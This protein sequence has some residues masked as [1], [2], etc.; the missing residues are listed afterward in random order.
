MFGPAPGAL[1]QIPTNVAYVSNQKGG[2]TVIDLSSF[3]PVK[4]LPVG[5]EGP[6]GIAITPDGKYLVT[7][8]QRTTDVSIIDTS[9]GRIVRRI[10]IGKNPEFLRLSR[11]GKTAF[12]TYEPSAEGRPPAAG[13]KENRKGKKPAEVAEIDLARGTVTRRL[14][15]G[16]ETEGIEFTPDG[17]RLAVTNEADD[18]ITVYNLADGKRVRTTNVASYGNRPR[19]IKISPD[20]RIYAVTLEFSD[21]LLILDKNF[22]VVKTVVTDAGPYGVA[23]DREGRLWVAAA[24]AGKLQVFDAH[25]FHPIASVPVGKRCWHFTLT[26]DETR[27]L[28]VCGRSNALYVIDAKRYDTVKVISGLE[29]PWGA[30]TYPEAN[31]SL[32]ARQ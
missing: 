13:E 5:G 14:V 25:D 24:R 22:A 3:E 8:N 23:F 28:D 31:G 15:A 6:R 18:T 20:G 27:V 9:T 11:D 4:S 21:K 32:D 29:L 10:P 17:K 1:A 12:V 30:V 16:L 19:G 7:A 26:P 2:V